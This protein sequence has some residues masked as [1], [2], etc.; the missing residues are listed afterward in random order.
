MCRNSASS[1]PSARH[2]SLSLCVSPTNYSA[3]LSPHPNTSILSE[4]LGFSRA[5]P[6]SL[7]QASKVLCSPNIQGPSQEAQVLS[8]NKYAE[9]QLVLQKELLELRQFQS[10]TI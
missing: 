2:T 9:D 5:S 4:V 6:S 8:E 10:T 7:A 1:F 3:S